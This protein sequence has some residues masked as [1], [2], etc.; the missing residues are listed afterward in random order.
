MLRSLSGC[1]IRSQ[2]L[3]AKRETE[4][5]RVKNISERPVLS[6]SEMFIGGIGLQR[7]HSPVLG[8][9]LGNVVFC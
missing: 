5:E 3:I 1:G 9:I 2:K 8:G 4:E 6:P 7:P